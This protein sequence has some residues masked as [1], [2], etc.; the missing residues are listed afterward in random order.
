MECNQSDKSYLSLVIYQHCDKI[1]MI[2]IMYNL[3]TLQNVSQNKHLFEF[4]AKGELC[5]L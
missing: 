1:I 3:R 4:Q 5:L 2:R